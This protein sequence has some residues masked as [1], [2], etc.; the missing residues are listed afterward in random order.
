MPQT[1][2][3]AQIIATV[4]SAPCIDP[5][6]LARLQFAFTITTDEVRTGAGSFLDFSRLLTS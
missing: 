4:S 3:L 2:D 6:R 1:F 5:E